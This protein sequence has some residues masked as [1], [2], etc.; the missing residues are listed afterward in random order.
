M[1]IENKMQK[2]VL[3]CFI[4][5][6]AQRYFSILSGI[7]I[8]DVKQLVSMDIYDDKQ[9]FFVH[10]VSNENN[11]YIYTNWIQ[12]RVNLVKMWGRSTEC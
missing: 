2:S 3:S 11:I 1:V 7:T 8:N 10:N 5:I 6:V 4:T 9:R 12:L